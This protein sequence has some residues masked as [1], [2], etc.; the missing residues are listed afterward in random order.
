MPNPATG[1]NQ[2]F[3]ASQQAQVFALPHVGGSAI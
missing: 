3:D 2:E 1:Q